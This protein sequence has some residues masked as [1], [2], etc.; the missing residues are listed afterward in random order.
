MMGGEAMTADLPLT[1][2][3][4]NIGGHVADFGPVRYTIYRYH[5]E[6]QGFIARWHRGRGFNARSDNI[7]VAL[8]LERGQGGMRAARAE[9]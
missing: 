9:A 4:N 8:T 5:L 1:W 7:T 6:E 2:T 3:I